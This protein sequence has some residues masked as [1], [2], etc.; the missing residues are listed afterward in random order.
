MNEN[1][2]KSDSYRKLFDNNDM[3]VNFQISNDDDSDEK[4]DIERTIRRKS[5]SHNG[6]FSKSSP[7]ID[8]HGKNIYH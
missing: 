8:D 3:N 7:D 1:F 6:I 5:E 4:H 2:I